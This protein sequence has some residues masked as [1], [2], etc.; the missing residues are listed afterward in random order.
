MNKRFRTA[1]ALA[2]FAC[3]SIVLTVPATAQSVYGS[4]FGTVTDKTGAAVP[5]ATVAVTDEAKGTVVTVTANTSGDYTVS[6]LAPDIYD[7]K[8]TFKGFKSFETKG[9]AIV[10]DVA[11]RIDPTLEV[12]GSETTVEV[13][14]D[15]QPLLKTDRADVAT[16]FDSQ[17]VNDL[18]IEGENFASLQLLLPGA[19]LLGWSHAADENPQQSRQIQVDGQAFGGVAYELDGTDNQD[20]ILGI[21]VV[22]P[23]LDTITDAK[24][25]TQN[26][27]AELGKAVSAA[28]TVQTKSGSNNFHGSAYDFR[29][30][31]A[32]LARDPFGQS[33]P[34]GS[35]ST[36]GIIPAGLKNKFGGTFG[37]PLSKDKRFYFVGYEGQ[38]QKSGVTDTD[39][40]P[41]KL[42]TETC[43]GHETGPSGIPGCDFS[44]YLANLPSGS[45][46][47]FN[48]TTGTPV[49]FPSNVIPAA[50][51]SQQWIN[52]LTLLE[53]YTK[54][55]SGGDLG[56]LDANSS[57][58][59]TGVFNSNMW[60]ARFDQTFS[61]KQNGFVRFTRWTDALGGPQQ[62][63]A[64]GGEGFG[65]G[66]Y[67]GNSTSADDSLS[68]GTDYVISPKLVTDVRLGYLRYN[69]IDI[70]NDEAVQEANNLGMPGFNTSQGITGGSPGWFLNTLAGGHQQPEYGDGLNISRCNCPLTEREDQFQIVNN[71]T[72]TIGNHAIKLGADLRYERNLRV[73]SDND[74]TGVINF[75][76]NPTSNGGVNDGVS[77]ATFALGDVTSFNRYVSASTNAKEFQKREFFYAQDTWRFNSKLTLNIGGRWELYYPES[78]NAPG[79]G[80]LLNI[81]DGYLHVA[82]VGGIKSNMGWVLDK[83]KTLEPRLSAAY[84]FTPK[85]VVRLGYGRSID[86]GVF[87]SIFGHTVTQNLPV[88]ANQALTAS[89]TLTGQAFCLGTSPQNSTTPS[90]PGCSYA[91]DTTASVQPVGGGPLPFTPPTVPADGLLPNPGNTVSTNAR[92]NPLRFPTLDA[93]NGSVQHALTSSL[94]VTAAYVG[95]KGTHNLSDGDGNTTNPNEAAINLPAQFSVNGQALHYDPTAPAVPTS[96]GAT[97]DANYL[98]RYYGGSLQAC[99]D[100]NYT[101]T[102][103]PNIT[104]PVGACGWSQSI[105][106]RGDDQNTH[107][108][109]L[110]ITVAQNTWHGLNLNGNY[111]YAIGKDF[112]SGYST[113]S[114]AITY[115]NDTNVRH[116]AA[117]VYGSYDLPIGKGKEFLNN[118][119]H[120]EDLALGGYEVSLVG[121][122][123]S[124]L[125]FGLSLNSC[126]D[127][128]PSS[129]GN[130]DAP[131]QPNA[132]GT[133]HTGLSK[134]VPGQGWTFYQ[135]QTLGS[136]FSDPGLDNIGNV[137]RNSY[138]GPHFFNT[139]LSLQKSFTVFESFALKFRFDAT[140]AVNHINPGNPGGNIQSAGSIT[141]EAPGPG[142]RQLTFGLSLKF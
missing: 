53:P 42:L 30:G 13:N 4:I 18:P 123:A 95:N 111:Q 1:L 28:Q 15:S 20:A 12:G 66:G 2:L 21:I 136:V 69:I 94:T 24:I 11:P 44:E 125:P 79:N 61:E 124:G 80:A 35:T 139:D 8:V 127:D 26:F 32:N 16:T 113:W 107:F 5:G 27:D 17:E 110:Q 98:L 29:F 36:A 134:F 37:G 104:L 43:L 101:P 63:G 129:G 70:K 31:N 55:E 67:G 135:P 40:L 85:T 49:P 59:G 137:R 71:W 76:N 120:A 106:Y 114:K 33:P 65:I 82:G 50:Q 62:Y 89:N 58:S 9:I 131:C 45:G 122:L 34:I 142:P 100:P 81:A 10:A 87:G 83:K 7:L 99:K 19:Q 121:T 109:A 74:R 118:I 73:P 56:G 112:A 97:S 3:A 60:V 96:A 41:S 6:H 130:S 22:N 23:A 115:G 88:L 54:L 92:P 103:D 14:A 119:N 133:L 102:I 72:K 132:T 77:F 138:F 48:N 128:I 46:Q 105:G 51:V 91:Y 78:V 140:N 68:V 126:T 64:A 47:I 38:R 39:T 75:N 52:L 84:Q 93:W 86:I 141:G 117:T 90:S 108:N 57:G 25:T 116:Q